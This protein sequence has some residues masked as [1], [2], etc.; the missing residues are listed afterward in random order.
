[1]NKLGL[2]IVFSMMSFVSLA[3]QTAPKVIKLEDTIRGNQ[4]QPKVLT[5]VPWQAASVK[6]SLPSQIV[7]RINKGFTPLERDDF[8]RQ[9]QFVTEQVSDPEQ[10]SYPEQGL[11]P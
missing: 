7:E 6:H 11:K 3:Q 9:L 10:V 8:S 5:I 2:L 4:E 1:M